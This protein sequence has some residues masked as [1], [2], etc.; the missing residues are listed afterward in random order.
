[1]VGAGGAVGATDGTA[2][3]DLR[4]RF[5]SGMRGWLGMWGLIRSGVALMVVGGTGV[6]AFETAS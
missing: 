2:R 6:G 5:G 1:M 3:G 4:R